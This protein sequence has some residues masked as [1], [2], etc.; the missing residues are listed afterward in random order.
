MILVERNA[1]LM[2]GGLLWR[3]EPG[4]SQLPVDAS[5]FTSHLHCRFDLH[6]NLGGRGL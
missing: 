2:W 3:A 1:R 6:G 5:G 4:G